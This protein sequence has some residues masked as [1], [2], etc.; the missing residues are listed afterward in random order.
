MR[1]AFRVFH[2]FSYLAFRLGIALVRLLP[3]DWA[4]AIGKAGGEVAYRLLFNR[5]A[6]ALAN[7]R[8]AFGRELPDTELRAL[9]RKH[10]QLVGAN[11]LAGFK[12]STLS[13]EK[14]WERITAEIPENR[15]TTGWIALISHIGNWELYSH[16]GQ[17]FPEYRFGAVYQTF[18]NPFID[19]YMRADRAKAGIALFDR[20][21]ELLS[22]VRFL[23]EGGVV[24]VL[25]D[26]G[27]GYS[28]LWSPLFGRLT[29]SSTLPARLAIRSGLPVVPL[30]I[31]TIGRARWRLT[32]SE[33]VYP[34]TDDPE[35]LTAQINA[36]LEQQI[37]RAPADWLWAHNRWKPLR[38]HFLLA[39]NV[40]PV[41]FPQDFDQA[42]LDPFRI[43]LIPPPAP[44]AARQIQPA[45]HAIRQGRPDTWLAVL[46]TEQTADLWNKSGLVDCVLKLN[47]TDSVAT[48]ASRIRAAGSFDAAIF[49]DH[50]LKTALA[51]WFAKIK[52]RV[53]LRSAPN[54]W[55]CNQHPREPAPG[56]TP[57][58]LALHIAQGVGADINSATLSGE[59]SPAAL[60]LT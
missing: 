48:I 36:L 34:A 7:L 18:A 39:R 58:E 3:I 44:A 41:F 50:N 32:I 22:C 45:V 12:A 43:L 13:E 53:G 24:G 57:T 10:F 23:R 40:R 31:N 30:A 55:L 20:R 46:A 9:N 29:S 5:R 27:A 52:I 15:Q 16:L 2:F 6:V 60:P 8:L 25:V 11:L 17:K 47:R 38:P 42:T 35:H 26:Q 59:Q 49:F 1:A 4:F 21:S 56:L 51:V 54:G 19:R 33:P 28:G 37:R 14:I